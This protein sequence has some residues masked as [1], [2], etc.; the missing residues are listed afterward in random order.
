VICPL[1][2][3]EDMMCSDANQ[4]ENFIKELHVKIKKMK[5]KGR[6]GN[7]KVNQKNEGKRKS[8]KI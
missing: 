8:S 6:W 5:Y 3:P 1:P 2:S 4:R 7:M